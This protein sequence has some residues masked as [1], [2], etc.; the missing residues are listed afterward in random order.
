MARGRRWR[1]AR[2]RHLWARLGVLLL[3][4]IAAWGA[5]FGWFVHR[6]IEPAPAVPKAGGIVVLTGGSG[7][8][9]EGFHLLLEGRAPRLL[10]SGVGPDTSLAEIADLAGVPEAGLEGRVDLDR[11]AAST[12]GNAR[13]AAAWVAARHL[14]SL[15]VVTSFYHMPRTILE[16]RAALPHVRL[17]AAPVRPRASFVAWSPALWRVVVAEYGKWLAAEAGLAGP[18]T[19]LHRRSP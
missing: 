2:R 18:V 9:Q 13:A 14:R 19:W 16:F 4:F 12:E 3:L 1:R 11:R 8:M 15:I 7:R 10:V 17:A 6:V 5:G